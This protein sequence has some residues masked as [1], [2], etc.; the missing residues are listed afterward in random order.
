MVI[1]YF[2]VPLADWLAGAILIATILGMFVAAY[3]AGWF[4]NRHRKRSACD[5]I[6]KEIEDTEI[7]LTTEMHTAT[8]RR[9]EGVYYKNAFLNKEAYESIIDSGVFIEFLPTAQNTLS[10]FYGNLKLRNELMVRI[11]NYHEIF[12]L[13]DTSNERQKQWNKSVLPYQL[14][15]TNYELYL[16][17]NLELLKQVIKDERPYSSLDIIIQIGSII[18]AFRIF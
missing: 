4:D 11:S 12:F 9:V 16:K 15:V 3:L 1:T 13:N 5:A 7:A 10:N 14:T 2:G 17:N 18:A 6:L 8:D